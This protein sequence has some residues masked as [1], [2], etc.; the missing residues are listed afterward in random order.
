MVSWVLPVLPQNLVIETFLPPTKTTEYPTG[1]LV[2]RQAH[3][4]S[5]DYP[6]KK[7]A[8]N[9]SDS[10]LSSSCWFQG[11]SGVNVLVL[12][13]QVSSRLVT[14][15]LPLRLTAGWKRCPSASGLS[16]PRPQLP[17]CSQF[18]NLLHPVPSPSQHHL[19][20][21]MHSS[22]LSLCQWVWSHPCSQPLSLPSPILWLTG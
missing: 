8:P 10:L 20:K 1:G 22:P 19:S 4:N 15:A 11:P 16:S 21:E 5:Q 6:V 17:L 18:S 12:S 2:L 13:L 14:D 9:N 7:E 3:S